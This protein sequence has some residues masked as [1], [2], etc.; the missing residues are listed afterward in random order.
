MD[1][2]MS[3]V[4]FKLMALVF[5]IR[6]LLRPRMD[7]LKEVGIEPGICILDYGCGS[8]SYIDPLAQLVG[9][10]GEIY[11][12]DIHPLAIK[13]V[14]KI[15]AHKAIANIKTI[16]SDCNTGLPNNHLDVVLLYDTFHNLS[17]PDDV[18]RELHRVLKSG[19]TLSFSDH[20][21]KAQDII[22]RVTKTGSFRL[23]TKG[24][25]TYSF[26]KVG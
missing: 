23:S 26:S 18:L 19:G 15:A 7:L 12:L 4:G 1:K 22:M 17:Q 2:P 16:E 5:R 6:D 20:H 21:M 10:S 13:E 8:G 9:I 25:K 3:K 24:Q 14:Q 11:A